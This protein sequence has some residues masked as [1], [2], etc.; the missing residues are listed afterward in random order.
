[1]KRKGQLKKWGAILL[2]LLATLLLIV[3]FV[4][5]QVAI[6]LGAL[7]LALILQRKYEKVLLQKYEDNMKE[8]R[9]K[10]LERR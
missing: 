3:G 9:A 2:L 7:G 6:S 1:M 8:K 10:A 5:K 4:T